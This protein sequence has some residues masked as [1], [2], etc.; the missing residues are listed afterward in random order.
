MT[1]PMAAQWFSQK[2]DKHSTLVNPQHGVTLPQ[3][4]KRHLL[5]SLLNTGTQTTQAL[6]N[7][8][9]LPVFRK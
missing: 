4:L 9:V 2:R 1:S 5:W 7:V 8:F 6:S 3:R